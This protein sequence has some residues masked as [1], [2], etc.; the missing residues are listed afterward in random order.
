MFTPPATAIGAVEFNSAGFT[1]NAR[2]GA[3]GTGAAFVLLLGGGGAL[4]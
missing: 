2:G 3:P 1:G 4:V